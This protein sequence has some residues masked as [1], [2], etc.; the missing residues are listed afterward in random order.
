M[1]FLTSHV[2]MWVEPRKTGH[3]PGKAHG[4][5]STMFAFKLLNA[6]RTTLESRHVMV[7][8]SSQEF[9]VL[10]DSENRAQS[11]RTTS[12]CRIVEHAE[13]TDDRCQRLTTCRN[14]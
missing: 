9:V 13:L 10:H 12:C 7:K 14:F 3:G 11:P 1:M 4:Y 6:I 2:D 8:I 5:S